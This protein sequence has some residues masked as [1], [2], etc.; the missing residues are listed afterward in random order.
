MIS[1]L[2]VANKSALL[3]VSELLM[4]KLFCV[5][6]CVSIVGMV[7]MSGGQTVAGRIFNAPFA[8]LIIKAFSFLA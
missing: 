5:L 1:Q 7:A 4:V 3:V 2:S 8:P 6:P